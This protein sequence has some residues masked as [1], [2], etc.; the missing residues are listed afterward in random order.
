MR[1]NIIT[2][3]VVLLFAGIFSCKKLEKLTQFN[4]KYNTEVTIKSTIGINIPVDLYTPQI[5]TNS[6]SE[7]SANNTHKN[8]VEAIKLKGLTLKI[9]SPAGSDF[10][11]LNFIEIY[12]KTD[13]LAEKKIAWKT[14]IPEDGLTTLTLET[15]DEDLKDYILADSFQM[16]TKTKTDHLITQDTE[17]EI[18]AVFWVDARILGL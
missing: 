11:F 15:S 5:T 2:I 8:L 9:K 13:T 3:L 14:D 16:R 18:D 17:I 6:E 4:L 1:K 12:I 10:D 7:L